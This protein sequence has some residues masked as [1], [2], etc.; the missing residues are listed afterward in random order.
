MMKVTTNRIVTDVLT[1]IMI[2]INCSKTASCNETE[3]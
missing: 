3:I 1:D 2:T